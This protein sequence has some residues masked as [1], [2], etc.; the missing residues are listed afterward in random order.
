[1]K[2]ALPVTLAL[3]VLC[4]LALATPTLRADCTSSYGCNDCDVKEI[5]GIEVPICVIDQR[6]DLGF[7]PIAPGDRILPKQ[8]KG[9]RACHAGQILVAIHVEIGRAHV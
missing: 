6:A 9:E 3:V 1:M 8:P 2:R 5:G 4:T 7:V